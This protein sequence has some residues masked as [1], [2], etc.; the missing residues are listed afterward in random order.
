[1]RPGWLLFAALPI[2]LFGQNEVRAT[3][4]RYH[5]IRDRDN[6]M[7]QAIAP[8]P[9][10]WRVDESQ[11]G[12]VFMSGPGGITVYRTQ[13]DR[14]AWSPDPFMQQ[15]IMQS[16]QQLSPV[17]PL[18]QILEQHVKPA[19]ASQGGRLLRSYP[20]PEVEGFWMRFGEG[21]V[22]TGS[23]R[24]WRALGSDWEDGNGNMTFVT[25]VQ[26]VFEQ[27]SHLSWILQSTSMEAPAEAFDEAKRDYLYA[28]GNTRINPDWQ[29]RMN[30]QLQGQIRENE[31][32]ARTMMESSRAA[33]RERMAAIEAAGNTARS[34]GQT[35]SEILDIS[36]A[37]YLKR[38]DINSAGHTRTIN[39][40]GERTLIGNHETGEHYNVQAGSKYYWVGSDGTYFGTDNALYDP[41]IDRRINEVQWTKFVVEQ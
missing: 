35:Y 4:I 37:G 1:M 11:Q 15:T 7:V 25:L 24:Q 18:E 10:D 26:A 8:I 6:G 31:S 28:V 32:F 21:M 40:I 23:R 3:E 13:T 38:D 30:G 5:E 17:V 27:P 29:R 14:F 19:F 41:T 22:Q 12:P 34:V 33:H 16:G 36:H 9:A 39:A 20:I 2:C